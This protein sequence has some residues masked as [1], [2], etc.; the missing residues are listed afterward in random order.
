MGLS[1][2]IL[3][4][5]TDGDSFY[6]IL[7]SKKLCY[8]Y[9]IERIIL[10][11]NHELMPVA[12]PMIS[13][14]DFPF[15]EIGNNK[16]AYGDYCIGFNQKWGETVGFS[17]VCYCSYGSCILRLINGQLNLARESNSQTL[18]ALAMIMFSHMKFVEGPLKTRKKTFEKYRFYDEREWRVVLSTMKGGQ[19][20][21]KPYLNVDDYYSF[22]KKCEGKP[23]LDVGVGFS[24]DDIHY[25]I[26]ETK[27]DVPQTR[28]IVGSG[29]HIFTKDEV[30]EDV[31][32]VEHHKEIPPSKVQLDLEA[33]LRQE[34]RLKNFFEN[35][36]KVE[37]SGN[38]N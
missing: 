22:K 4:H 11:Q 12:F 37:N 9:S 6:K 24:Y 13:V 1:S 16:W 20:E 31:I 34:E 30:I 5:Q 15:S 21:I 29:I 19:T 35:R 2:N 10:N 23:L 32:G 28:G 38:Y 17:P 25:I 33:A 14:S 3:W 27:E 7:E 36:K 26:V 8:S 18:F